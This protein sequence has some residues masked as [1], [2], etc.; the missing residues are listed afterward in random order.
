MAPIALPPSTALPEKQPAKTRHLVDR[1]FVVPP[2]DVVASKGHILELSNGQEVFD[3]TGGAAV[4][5]IG[6]G[7]Q[8]VK[9][10]ITKQLDISSYCNSM[11]F[12]SPVCE[13]LAKEVIDST[14]GLMGRVWFCSSGASFH[15]L[16]PVSSPLP[17]MTSVAS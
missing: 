9:E 6:H 5:C 16:F 3:A 11:L 14:G 17:T 1:S 4:A 7:N 15:L 13:E 12:S 8:E 10:A 2:L